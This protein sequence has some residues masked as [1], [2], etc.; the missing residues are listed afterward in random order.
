VATVAT[1]AL[2][3]DR[4]WNELLLS[5]ES[6]SDCTSERAAGQFN[7]FGAV[8]EKLSVDFPDTNT[9]QVMSARHALF[10]Y[11]TPGIYPAD[12]W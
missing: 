1:V 4:G 3:P 8:E 5:C 12:S 11:N 6:E 10:L 9:S 7:I 2:A